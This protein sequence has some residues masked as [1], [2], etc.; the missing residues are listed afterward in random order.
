MKIYYSGTLLVKGDNV[1]DILRE[2]ANVMLAFG[3]AIG[4][5]LNK[6]IKPM[7]QGRKK[8]RSK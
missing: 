7:H 6:R 5:W 1:E 3:Y 2:R 4:D 8:K